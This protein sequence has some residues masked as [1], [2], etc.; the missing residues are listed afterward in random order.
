V[1]PRKNKDNRV[2]QEQQIDEAIFYNVAVRDS[3]NLEKM[4][5][6]KMVHALI[7][8]C[9]FI[10]YQK[11]QVFQDLSQMIFNVFRFEG[12]QSDQASMYRNTENQLLLTNL[13]KM[14]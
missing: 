14:R 13:E 7:H 3:K 9:V 12:V 2:R 10:F 8:K 11:E 5:V 4:R 6:I 1:S